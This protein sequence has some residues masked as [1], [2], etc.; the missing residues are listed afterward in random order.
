MEQFTM[1]EDDVLETIQ[2]IDIC[3]KTL[4]KFQNNFRILPA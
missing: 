2:I 4:L 1:N 3:N